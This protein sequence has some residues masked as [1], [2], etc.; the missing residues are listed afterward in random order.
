MNDLTYHGKRQVV[1]QGNGAGG[2]ITDIFKAK[3]ESK[4]RLAEQ[5]ARGNSIEPTGIEAVG[6]F[7]NGGSSNFSGSLYG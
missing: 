5:M 3:D 2:L 7:G 1:D 6:G 4:K